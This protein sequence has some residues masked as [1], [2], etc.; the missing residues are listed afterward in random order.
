MM[1]EMVIH[2]KVIRKPRLTSYVLFRGKS[3][4]GTPFVYGEILQTVENNKPKC[5]LLP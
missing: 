3:A 1:P 5:F 4:D 2:L